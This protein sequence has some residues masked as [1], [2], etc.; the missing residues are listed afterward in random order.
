MFTFST[1]DVFLPLSI[2]LMITQMLWIHFHDILD[3]GNDRLNYG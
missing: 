2:C 1:E 3:T